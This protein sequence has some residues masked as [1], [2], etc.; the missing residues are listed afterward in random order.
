MD[1]ADKNYHQRTI[2]NLS[3]SF[4][5]K[6]TFDWFRDK[7]R[8]HYS[9]ARKL[10]KFRDYEKVPDLLLD[11]IDTEI[12]ILERF[13][14]P[15]ASEFMTIIDLF[16]WNEQIN[17]R[18]IEEL[19]K[20][21]KETAENYLLEPT[22][23]D[24]QSLIDGKETH[25]TAHDLLPM[26]EIDRN[27]YNNFLYETLFYS[28][29]YDADVILEEMKKGNTIPLEL[30]D[31]MHTTMLLKG[32][33]NKQAE[34][35]GLKFWPD[36]VEYE[37]NVKQNPSKKTIKQ[38]DRVRESFDGIFPRTFSFDEGYIC[39]IRYLN[40]ENPYVIV[41][42]VTSLDLNMINIYVYMPFEVAIKM[43]KKTN[44]HTVASP[45]RSMLYDNFNQ[46]PEITDD[47]Q[48]REWNKTYLHFKG[49]ELVVTNC[50]S[51]EKGSAANN[52]NYYALNN[53]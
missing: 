51:D 12:E 11:V 19:F 36:F 53:F 15:D 25:L 4:S 49:I 38:I 46:N 24:K 35:L 18:D 21:L 43:L 8:H 22:K 33:L 9:S 6:E 52:S 13:G 47:L 30:S 2:L 1:E 14:L 20:T 26:I 5:E 42:L 37:K 32:D 16:S 48:I 23:T 50:N 41:E 10:H 27:I 40:S 29:D 3:K 7:V 34:Q 31:N 17:D 28:K 39:S 45:L 44:N